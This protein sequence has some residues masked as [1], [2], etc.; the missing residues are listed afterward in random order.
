[1]SLQT[2]FD[3]LTEEQQI[4]QFGAPT[5]FATRVWSHVQ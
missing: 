4:F 3:S 5:K 2:L 1:M